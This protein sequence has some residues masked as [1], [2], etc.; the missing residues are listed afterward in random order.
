MGAASF[1]SNAGAAICL[2]MGSVGKTR[3][4][5]PS[6]I[7]RRLVIRGIEFSGTGSSSGAY[8]SFAKLV[9]S[10][11]F[12]ERG[13]RNVSKPGGIERYDQA[14]TRADSRICYGRLVSILE[15]RGLDGGEG[16]FAL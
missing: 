13:W 11:L 6:Q 3:A 2:V 4:L 14:R 10:L 15:H 7:F 1:R 16:R 8:G 9:K 12:P 5:Q